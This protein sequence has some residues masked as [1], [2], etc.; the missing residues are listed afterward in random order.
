MSKPEGLVMVTEDGQRIP[1]DLKPSPLEEP[2][3]QHWE[4]M[5]EGDLNAIMPSVIGF[6]GPRLRSDQAISFS[7]P[8]PGWDTF[9]WAQRVM[10]NSRH[11]F[12]Y[13]DNTAG[14][15]AR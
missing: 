9:E 8:G 14:D 5:I 1:I 10:A 12:A 13:Y 3:I 6:D 2:G 4:P 11:V 15:Y 7:E